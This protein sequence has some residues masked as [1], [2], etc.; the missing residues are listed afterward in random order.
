MFGSTTAYPVLE[1]HLTYATASG[2]KEWVV[3]EACWHDLLSAT[4]QELAGMGLH[5][6]QTLVRLLGKDIYDQA[7]GAKLLLKRWPTDAGMECPFPGMPDDRPVP[8]DLTQF[9]MDV[10]MFHTG[11]GYFQK[12][13]DRLALMHRIE[14]VWVP[15][16]T[17][18]LVMAGV[19]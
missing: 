11:D 17:S 5:T 6:L 8:L 16:L 12:R 10:A 3:D 7:L 2:L 19:R 18:A 4:D 15:W 1:L 14:A 9:P 13:V